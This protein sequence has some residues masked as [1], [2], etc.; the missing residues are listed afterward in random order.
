MEKLDAELAKWL[1]GL[2]VIVKRLK[3]FIEGEG[4]GRI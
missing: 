4:Y 2:D 3:E 1:C